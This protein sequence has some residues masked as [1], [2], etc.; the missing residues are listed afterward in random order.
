MRLMGHRTKEDR[1]NHLEGIS[2]INPG[3][4]DVDRAAVFRND[5]GWT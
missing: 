1:R 2:D 4:E 3:R 5:A